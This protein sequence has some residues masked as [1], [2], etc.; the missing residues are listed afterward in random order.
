MRANEF[1]SEELGET[2]PEVIEA[3]EQAAN[4][5][6]YPSWDKVPTQS[7]MTVAKLANNILKLKSP[8]AHGKQFESK[9]Q[10][11]GT[12]YKLWVASIK[13]KQP[14]YVGY[15]DVTATAPNIQIARTLMKAQYGV[16][17]WEIGSIKEVK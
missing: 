17:D 16:Q 7:R 6:G 3:L 1:I 12:N 14:N 9:N 15:I 4:K 5:L 10:N 2:P 8:V 13:I 11:P